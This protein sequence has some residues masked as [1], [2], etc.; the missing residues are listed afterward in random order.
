M[1]LPRL[2]ELIVYSGKKYICMTYFF[3]TEPSIVSHLY[4]LIE[5]FWD[6]FSS[7]QCSITPGPSPVLDMKRADHL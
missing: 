4:F 6:V 5:F 7:S 1:L 2:K 3:K